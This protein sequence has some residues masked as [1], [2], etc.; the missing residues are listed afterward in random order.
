M[1]RRRAAA[2]L[3]GAT[4]VALT[5]LVAGI[6]LMSNESTGS[7][8]TSVAR[9]TYRIPT[10]TVPAGQTVPALDPAPPA[11]WISA[12][13]VKA[14]P[15]NA[16]W[17]RVKAV[18]DDALEVPEIDCQ[19]SKAAA[20]TYAT[21]L[22]GVRLGD[23]VYVERARRRISSV[24]GSE[25]DD[26]PDCGGTQVTGIARELFLYIVSAD[27]IGLATLD[28]PLDGRFRA[29]LRA[30]ERFEGDADY[31]LG[32]LGD[33]SADNF[34]SFSRTSLLAMWAY[35]GEADKFDSVLQV[36]R[37]WFGDQ[38][39]RHRFERDWLP[40]AD[41]WTCRPPARTQPV[42]GPS[43]VIEG[44]SMDGEIATAMQRQGEFRWPPAETVYLG[45][46]LGAAIPALEVARRNGHPDAFGW[47]FH[48]VK[49]MVGFAHRLNTEAG[50]RF[51]AAPD[52]D[53]IAW[54]VNKTYGTAFPTL[55]LANRSENMGFTDWTHG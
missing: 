7:T 28:P 2:A 34:G 23:A 30:L 11:I 16:A 9:G 31:T 47:Q 37:Y 41:S 33:N 4:A 22:V 18:A 12:A 46:E 14:L 8:R 24:I 53:W 3:I 52:Y 50:L 54:F 40:E 51:L 1:T 20:D 17:D 45:T 42:Q 55:P 26:P 29:W 35:L 6:E 43:C 13:E 5:G 44:V 25:R 36:V 19:N 27:L 15:L 21:A 49:R 10:A 48:A 39:I 38:S 32:W